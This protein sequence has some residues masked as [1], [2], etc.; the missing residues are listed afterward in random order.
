MRNGL[1]KIGA[2]GVSIPEASLSFAL[3]DFARCRVESSHEKRTP[4]AAPYA[5]AGKAGLALSHD[6][7]S[8]S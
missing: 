1:R 8:R 2:K 5:A 6:N 4:R 7:F 3:S